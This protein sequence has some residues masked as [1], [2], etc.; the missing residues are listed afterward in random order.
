VQLS[1]DRSDALVRLAERWLGPLSVAALVRT[2]AEL[3]RLRD[4]WADS[5]A[6]QRYA[7]LH[8]R[9]VDLYDK[10]P[11]N[12]LRNDALRHC[13]TRYVVT[14]DVDFV[15]NPG[16]R[17]QLLAL[18]ALWADAHTD[19]ASPTPPSTGSPAAS[20]ASAP[21][22]APSTP[23]TTVSL[24]IE[25]RL[26]AVDWL[27]QTPPRGDQRTHSSSRLAVVLAAL[28][29]AG[30]T[31]AVQPRS[32][33]EVV[34]ENARDLVYQVHLY[35]G[36]NAHRATHYAQWYAS[37]RPYEVRYDY[38]WEPYVML[39]RESCPLFDERFIGYG[40]D[41]ASHTYELQAAGFRFVV[42]PQPFIIHQ[43]HGVPTWRKDQG[44]G[45]A[46]LRWTQFAN[47]VATRYHGFIEPV[48]EWLKQACRNGDCPPFWEWINVGNDT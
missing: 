25:E 43:D 14:L 23:T 42:A 3:D 21:L 39:L 44:S 16:M 22:A 34:V 5:A 20:S 2:Q 8:V 45:D 32:K 1:A 11:A 40:N 10:Y 9:V 41:K 30:K 35:K 17:P 18:R 37:T 13:S 47:D 48:P 7:D 6:L 26:P 19:T 27:P 24:S 12:H 36:V 28:E 29:W 4:A 38:L 46:W 31:G 33:R 15:P